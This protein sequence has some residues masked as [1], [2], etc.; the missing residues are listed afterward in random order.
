[1]EQTEQQGFQRSELLATD[2]SVTNLK[3]AKQAWFENSLFQIK[4][5]EMK[6]T[7]SDIWN[8]MDGV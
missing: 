5:Q 1:M 7:N 4:L 2:G 3:K 6:N 8:S